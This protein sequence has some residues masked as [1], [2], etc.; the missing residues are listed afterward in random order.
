[1][2]W[3]CT[4]AARLGTRSGIVDVCR[5]MDGSCVFILGTLLDTIYQNVRS[6]Y[7]TRQKRGFDGQSP[8]LTILQVRILN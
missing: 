6:R 2:S 3:S 5:Y 1:M 7:A 4:Q 8:L